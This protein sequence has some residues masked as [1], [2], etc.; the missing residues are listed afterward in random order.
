MK[1]GFDNEK[2]IFSNSTSTILVVDDSKTI[3][4]IESVEAYAHEGSSFN[5]SVV[6][7]DALDS[8]IKSSLILLNI[9][10]DEDNFVAGYETYT[11][12]DGEAIFS[13]NL[14]YGTYLAKTYYAGN[15]MYFETFN[16]N[17]I[18]ISPL[19]NVTET[20]L[21]GNDCEI[22]NGYDDAYSVLLKTIDGDVIGNA[23]IEFVVKGNSYYSKTDNKCSICSWGI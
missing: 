17:Y 7:M 1:I 15:E 23:T 8:N 9:T 21:F 16:S 10:D 2:Y 11:N 13:L 6:L 18:Y 14:T 5:Y 4:N 22:I 3:T 20:I 12:N 19:E